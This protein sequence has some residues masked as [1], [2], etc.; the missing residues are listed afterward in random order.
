MPRKKAEK[1]TD[2]VY[3]TVV[4]SGATK[5]ALDKAR[6]KTPLSRFVRVLIEHSVARKARRTAKAPTPA[7]EAQ[8]S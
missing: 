8:P 2:L 6:G 4:V 5:Q 3:L 7:P 1:K